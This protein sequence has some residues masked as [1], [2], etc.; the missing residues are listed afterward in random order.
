MPSILLSGPAGGGKSQEARRLREANSGPAVIAD[1]QSIYAAISGDVR[2]P[3]GKFPLR[4]AALLPITEY[5]RRAIVT[6]ARA[7]EIDVIAT[8]S[9]GSLARR[10]QLLDLLGPGA[11]ER[12][13]D[14]GRAG[15]IDRLA[16][17]GGTLSGECAS[18]ISRWYERL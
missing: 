4:D 6:G 13:L 1:F 7:R 3:D 11:S 5:V 16:D 15:V 8:N 9:D 10:R 12:I 2:G 17:S 14:P 18:A